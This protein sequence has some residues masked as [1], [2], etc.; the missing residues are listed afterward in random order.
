MIPPREARGGARP[1]GC[2]RAECVIGVTRLQKLLAASG[3]GSRRAIE[4]WI[5]AGRVTIGGGPAKPGA[6]GAPGED[7]R[8]DGAPIRIVPEAVPGT[9]ELLLSPKPVG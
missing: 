7:V 8:L 4:E 6:R 5:R 9:R 2:H 3:L 1:A